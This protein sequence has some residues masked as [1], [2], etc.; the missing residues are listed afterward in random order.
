MANITDSRPSYYA[1]IKKG[2]FE[3]G[4]ATS[5]GWFGRLLCGS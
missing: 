2:K 3:R 1:R 4:K 5:D